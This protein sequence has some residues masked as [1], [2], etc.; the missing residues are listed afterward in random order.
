MHFEH[1]L[2]TCVLLYSQIIKVFFYNSR[3]SSSTLAISLMASSTFTC[4]AAASRIAPCCR[5]SAVSA[6]PIN[7]ST[8]SKTSRSQHGHLGKGVVGGRSGRGR[9]G[10]RVGG[11][12]GEGGAARATLG[13]FL[14]N[15]IGV[16]NTDT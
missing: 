15:R 4:Q 9:V 5:S 12:E 7:P 8:R 1:F 11:S 13:A 10:G 6:V 2:G 3:S 14:F 16:P